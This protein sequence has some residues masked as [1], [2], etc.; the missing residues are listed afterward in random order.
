MRLADELSAKA[1]QASA[2]RSSTLWRTQAGPRPGLGTKRGGSVLTR[3]IFFSERAFSRGASH[4]A[5]GVADPG[6][7]AQDDRGLELLR[8]LDE[9]AE[10]SPWPPGCRRARRGGSWQNGHNCGYPARFARGVHARVVGHAGHKSAF[11]ADIAQGHRRDRRH[12]QT[13]MLHAC[14]I[15]R[16]PAR[17]A[18][19]A[20]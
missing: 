5:A 1:W 9:Q 17:E 14:T 19:A 10:G 6:G 7:G 11:H 16:A 13:H 8:D 3:P 12:I 20:T 18:P 2:S 4:Q 15:L